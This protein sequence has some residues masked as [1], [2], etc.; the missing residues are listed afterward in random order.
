MDTPDIRLMKNRQY[1][2]IPVDQIKVINSR[3]RDE[4]QFQMNTQSIEQAGLMMPIRVNDKFQASTGKYELICGEGRLIAH[5]RLG[6]TEIMA[7]VVTCSRK[8]A[9]LQSLIENIA[10]SKPGTMDYARELKRLHDEGW[11][12][13]Q[14]ATISCRSSAYIRQFVGLV[15]KGEERLIK[16]VE[17]GL[18]PISF[19]VQVAQSNDGNVQA[20][21]MDAFDKGIINTE[22]F[23]QA[24]K[25]INARLERSRKRT[26]T[27]ARTADISLKTLKR[28]I[29]DIT[30]AKESFVREAKSKENRFLTLL[31]A[32]NA[33]W[34]DANFLRIADAESLAKRPELHGDFT[35]DTEV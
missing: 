11:S 34:Q 16:G 19:A 23:A 33:L 2:L 28:D 4:E 25:I 30:K 35:Y 26:E 20:V 15:E 5:Q 10:R 13:E 32:V 12:Y 14:I 1:K 17:Q 31:T 6:A 21:L 8:D 9:Y 22:N 3:M 7:E 29:T 18:F 24:R 27:D